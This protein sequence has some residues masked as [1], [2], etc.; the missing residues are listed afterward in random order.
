M[1]SLGCVLV[2]SSVSQILTKHG[3][4]H[5]IKTISS[6][7][8][9]APEMKQVL[10]LKQ[11]ASDSLKT[12]SGPRTV[13]DGYRVVSSSE[14]RSNSPACRPCSESPAPPLTLYKRGT[15]RGPG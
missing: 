14:G 12:A 1:V 11:F 2:P 10:M 4:I 15:S 13:F 9:N 7:E 5:K 8:V 3:C 6:A